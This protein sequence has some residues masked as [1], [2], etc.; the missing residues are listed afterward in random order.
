MQYYLSIIAIFKNEAQNFKE[1][2]DHYVW[3]GLDNF[4][5]WNYFNFMDKRCKKYT[6]LSDMIKELENGIDPYKKKE[7]ND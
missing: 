7:K 1:W 6:L 2:L 4:R 5:N 3:Q